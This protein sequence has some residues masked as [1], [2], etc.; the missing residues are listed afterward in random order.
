MGRG[1]G[2]LLAGLFA[3]R[4]LGFGCFGTFVV[5]VLVF[6]LLGR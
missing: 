1:L 4:V 6:I 5:I 3:N 2:A